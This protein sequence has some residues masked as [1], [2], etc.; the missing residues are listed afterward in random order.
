M[1]VDFGGT[2]L[3][4]GEIKGDMGIVAGTQE[5]G[6]DMQEDLTQRSQRSPGGSRMILRGGSF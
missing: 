4:P 5:E 2:L 6:P 3:S 1:D